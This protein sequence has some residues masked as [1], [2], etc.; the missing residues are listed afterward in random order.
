MTVSCYNPPKENMMFF[1]AASLIF[2][3]RF[4]LFNQ[5]SILFL[6]AI[7]LFGTLIVKH[8]L[9]L[10]KQLFP[11]FCLFL[12]AVVVSFFLNSVYASY[13]DISWLSFVYLISIYIFFIF[14][15]TKQNIDQNRCLLFWNKCILVCAILGI[16]QFML[17]ALNSVLIDLSLIIPKF[18]I[19]SNSFG[20]I[21]YIDQTHWLRSN[22]FFFLEPSFFSQFLAISIIIELLY[23]MSVLRISIFSLALIL[24]FSGTG[25]LV[26]MFFLGC[27]FLSILN[28]KKNSLGFKKQQIWLLVFLI[29]F[30]ILMVLAAI[31]PVVNEYFIGRISE[32]IKSGQGDQVGSSS[33]ARFV[34]P[35]LI[36]LQTAEQ[37]SMSFFFGSGPG[38]GNFSSLL[39]VH[40]DLCVPAAIF[41]YYGFIAAV[42]FLVYIF[43]FSFYNIKDKK[44]I[45]LLTSILFMYAFCSGSLLAPNIVFVLLWFG[46]VL[47]ARNNHEV[48]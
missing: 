14:R 28:F 39:P 18:L 34:A 12:S 46:W 36:M 44:A 16:I 26:L 13:K 32:F 48:V 3:Q 10:N 37:S 20:S 47:Q 21:A 8:R 23:F 6:L 24:S 11:L 2:L 19:S 45:L 25:I 35:F 29:I 7:F 15:I 33:Y 17:Y 5:L 4:F 31:T 22:G 27:Y 38:I 41:V 1:A 30:G 9:V 43:S 40:F 42:L